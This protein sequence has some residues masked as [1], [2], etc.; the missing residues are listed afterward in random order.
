[1][2]IRKEIVECLRYAYEN[3]CPWHEQS[4]AIKAHYIHWPLLRKKWRTFCLTRYWCFTLCAQGK[5]HATAESSL[6]FHVQNEFN[7]DME[8]FFYED[9]AEFDLAAQS[10]ETMVVDSETQ[11][12]I[13][14]VAPV[15][16]PFG[17]S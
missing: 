2:L 12:D 6:T 13:L 3:G 16:V 4:N 1:M 17:V 15:G 11:T 9:I 14:A 8:Q 10:G 5:N 7:D